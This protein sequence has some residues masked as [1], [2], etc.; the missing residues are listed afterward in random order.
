MA[1]HASVLKIDILGGYQGGAEPWERTA[2]IKL[3]HDGFHETHLL[4]HSG[5]RA[6]LEPSQVVDSLLT[7]FEAASLLQLLSHVVELR[8]QIA[9]MNNLNRT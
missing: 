4:G 8:S 9:E 1:I 7:E 2:S 6:P 5:D 3:D